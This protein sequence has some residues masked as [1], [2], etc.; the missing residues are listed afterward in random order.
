MRAD[1]ATDAERLDAKRLRRTPTARQAAAPRV[2]GGERR[3]VPIPRRPV[4]QSISAEPAPRPI[5][6]LAPAS[7]SWLRMRRPSA[8]PSRVAVLIASLWLSSAPG[9]VYAD[10]PLELRGRPIVAVEVRGDTVGTTQVR[11]LGIPL[12]APL[13]RGLVR[14][15]IRRLFDSGR[16]AEVEIDAVPVRGGVLLLAHLK[17]R[18]V[19]RRI[20][21]TGNEAVD[22]QEILR[23][24]AVSEGQEISP[25]GLATMSD[26][27][28]SAYSDRGYDRARVRLEVRDTDDPSRKILFIRIAEGDPTTIERIDFQG[29]SPPPETGVIEALEVGPGDILDR[30]RF[31]R[32]IQET[33]TLLRTRGYLEAQLGAPDFEILDGRAI[34]R[35]ASFVGPRYGVAIRGFAPLGRQDVLEALRLGEE[36]LTGQAVLDSMQSRILDLYR[37]HGFHDAEV[38]VERRRGARP[39]EAWL[40]TTIS[41]GEELDVVAISFPGA[42]HF[43]SSFLRTQVHSYLE[44]EL[45]GSSSLRPVDT[46]VVDAIGFGGS[47]RFSRDQPR[48]LIVDPHR[49]FHE[50]TYERA[51][52]HI[53]ELYQAAGFLSVEVG[54]ARLEVQEDHRATVT[55]PVVEGARTL[56]YG[57][58]VQGNATVTTREIALASHL[59]RGDGFSYLALEESRSRILDLYHERGH[60]YARVDP[61]VTFS[62]DRTRALLTLEIVEGF[63]VRVGSIHI[64]GADR[65]S[66]SLI[67]ARLLLVRGDLYRPSLARES[68]ERLMELGVFGG[69][70]VSPDGAELPERIK[71]ITVTVS[72]RP[73]QV[74]DLNLGLSTGEGVRGGFEYGYRNLFGYAIE[75]NMRVQ[76]AYQLFF[77]EKQIEQRFDALVLGDRLE[78]RVGGGLTMPHVNF[79]PRTRLSLDL[80]HVRDNERDFGLDKNGISLTATWQP[81]RKFSIA[82]SPIDVENNT[83]DLFVGDNLNEYLRNTTD[84]RLERLL[85]VPEGES[86]IVSVRTT[87][88]LDLRDSPFTPTRGVFA[89]SSL[90]W[91]RTLRTE[92]SAEA[93]MPFFSH[94]FKFSFTGSGYLPFGGNVVF[95]SQLRLGR[96]F[97]LDYTSKTYPNRSFY[98][99]GVSSLRG[100]LEDALIPQDVADRIAADPL[101]APNDVVRGGDTFVLLRNEIRFPLVGVLRGGVFAEVGNL[102]ADATAFEAADLVDLRPTGGVGLRLS[103]PVGP[104]A[105]DYGFNLLRRA[106]LGEPVGAFHFSMGLF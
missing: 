75:A 21:V 79:L 16:W 73:T 13:T 8:N 57:L 53:S 24:I 78:R 28:R 32:S 55:I 99:G 1:A 63:A 90:S 82:I 45:P 15:A 14:T 9:T 50:P 84:R 19:V 49:V 22:D 60:L 61:K 103:T 54:P 3:R 76:L 51:T 89:S 27:L 58:E 34:V 105:A 2:S 64:V 70:T 10:V 102:W 4:T 11:E 95:A 41:P 20:D 85:R 5:G 26:S 43:R 36:R 97:H 12:G 80:V 92:A 87:T 42:Q 101:L 72:E 17:P 30:E 71:A 106:E 74:V 29:Q 91:A 93:S 52:E 25:D 86:T 98:L 77:V 18:L 83:I 44:E 81:V 37:R 62:G 47:R 39:G 23:A 48:P 35:I 33:E 88:T 104:I 40:M 7:R 69:A 67:R 59:R 65:T 96:I 31:E 100:F 94:F 38:A 56:L 46:A 6:H 66:E 68:E